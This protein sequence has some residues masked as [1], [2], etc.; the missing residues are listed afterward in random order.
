MDDIERFILGETDEEFLCISEE[1]NQ[2]I[3][4]SMMQQAELRVDILSY[5][6]EP[7]VYDNEACLEAVEDL[8]LRSRYSKIR[9][10][11]HDA[12]KISRRGHSFIYLARRV[13]SLIQLRSMAEVHK[14]FRENFLIVDG[15]GVMHRPYAD[16]L[17]ATVNFKDAP[18]ARD[19]SKI[20]EKLWKDAEPDPNSQYLVI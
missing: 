6:L 11:I 7:D 15:I 2:D 19:L 18:K 14:S 20:F 10:L 4:C 5:D 16:T 1:D 3:A 12:Q 9:I 13:G 8:A 17:A